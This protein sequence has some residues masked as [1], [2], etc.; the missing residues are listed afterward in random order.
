M[1]R[2]NIPSRYKSGLARITS[3]PDAAFDQLT[4]ALKELKRLR[5]D[6]DAIVQVGAAAPNITA[7]DL[8]SLLE[9]LLGLQLARSLQEK[10]AE[11]F[12]NEILKEL[13]IPGP[14]QLKLSE[15]DRLKFINRL[16]ILLGFESLALV[17]K[18]RDL[19][20]EHGHVFLNG[21]VITDLRPVFR[22]APNETPLGVVLLH[23]LKL[24]YLDRQREGDR[25]TF[26]IALDE[27]DVASLKRLLDRAEIK[28]QTLRSTLEGAGI[29]CLGEPQK[30]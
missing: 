6:S 5:I 19:Q 8:D 20:T 9:V 1:P 2:L 10:T 25:S 26:Y 15:S 18:A 22:G 23:I 13:E 28:A 21:R 14:E 27:N 24:S 30:T 4:S 12:S 29:K 7:E 11:Q 17:A 3:I 16:S